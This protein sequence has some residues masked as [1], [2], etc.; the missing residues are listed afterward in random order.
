MANPSPELDITTLSPDELAAL[1]KRISE[2]ERANERKR[3]SDAIRA[4]Q[5]A[6]KH[7]G[8]KLSDLFPRLDVGE[9]ETAGSTILYRNPDNPDEVWSGRG[10]RPSWYV[11]KLA[12]GVDAETMRV[13][14]EQ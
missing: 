11:Q 10:R 7:F 6:A 3:R 2:V 5:D 13:G 8:F 1:K 12:A 14:T 4:V 9:G